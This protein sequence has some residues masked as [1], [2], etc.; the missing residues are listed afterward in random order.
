MVPPETNIVIWK[1]PRKE[2]RSEFVEECKQHG[3]LLMAMGNGSLVRA[4]PHYGNTME[5]MK[6]AADFIEGIS[7]KYVVKS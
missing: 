5:D 1:M 3:V 6:R 2:Q 7:K 4:I